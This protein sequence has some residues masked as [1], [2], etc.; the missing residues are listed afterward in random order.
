MSYRRPQRPPRSGNPRSVPTASAASPKVKGYALSTAWNVS[1]IISGSAILRWRK[2]KKTSYSMWVGL[3]DVGMIYSTQNRKGA[4]VLQMER[5]Q[6]YIAVDAV[7]WGRERWMNGINARVHSM[8][9][10]PRFFESSIRC[11]SHKGQRIPQIFLFT[12]NYILHTLNYSARACSLDTS[13]TTLHSKHYTNFQRFRSAPCD[14]W[15]F[16]NLAMNLS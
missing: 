1:K 11:M 6:K 5:T 3:R 10:T 7:A 2:N 8:Q 12:F 15:H 16:K 14:A 9:N 4:E 13:R